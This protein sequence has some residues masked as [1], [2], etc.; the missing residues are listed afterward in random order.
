MKDVFVV[1][2]STLIIY[3]TLNMVQNGSFRQ[4]YLE[5]DILSE[6][7]WLSEMILSNVNYMER[8]VSVRTDVTMGKKNYPTFEAI[9][10]SFSQY[11]KMFVKV[12]GSQP[13][14]TR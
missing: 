5:D 10:V 11:G 4:T 14:R 1:L 13:A 8:L 12:R 6:H 9:L 7:M 2:L 3:F